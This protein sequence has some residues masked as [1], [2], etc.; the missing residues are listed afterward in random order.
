MQQIK[1]LLLITPTASAMLKEI[2][3]KEKLE[4]VYL[5]IDVFPGGCMC[6]GGYRYSLSLVDEPNPDDIVEEIEGLKVVV[7]RKNESLIRGSTLDFIESLQKTG[8]RIENPNVQTSSCGC[9]SH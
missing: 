3:A 4:S 7:D 5:K 2:I 6:N 9:G 1:P 8:F